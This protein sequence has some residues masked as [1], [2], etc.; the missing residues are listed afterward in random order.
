MNKQINA[1][2]QGDDYQALFFWY[3]ALK[4][5]YPHTGVKKVVYEADNV[6]SFDDVVVYYKKDK[7]GLDCNN[8]PIN[9]DFFQVKFHVTNSNAFTWNGL[10]DPKFVNA[11][12]VSIM[13]RLRNAQEMYKE[14]IGTR[15][16]LVST[17]S[18]DSQDKLSEIVSNY[19]DGI[20]IDKLFDNRPRTQMA[21]MRRSM[22]EH[23]NLTED[24]LKEMLMSFRIWHNYSSYQRIIEEINNDLMHLG[25]KP[26]ENDSI[27]NPYV[28]LIKQWSYRGKSEFNKD[29][30]IEECKREGLFL[31]NN[32]SDSDYEDVGI[33]SFYRRAENMQDE[34]EIMLCLLKFFNG[35]YIKSDYN[36]DGEIFDELNEFTKEFNS[37][38]KYR[39]HLDTHLSI[40]FV[41]G[42]LLDSKSGIEIYPMQKSM[43][44]KEF[45]YPKED[46]DK[47]YSDWQV[48]QEIVS[49]DAKD[50]ALV[51]S[52]THDISHEVN[53]FIE[54]VKLEISKIIYCNVGG[55]TRPDAILDGM[56]AHK[57]AISL[58]GLLKERRDR[59]EKKNKLHIFAA[60]PVGFM[61][62]LGKLSRSF[63][64]VVL[65]EHD[66]EGLRDE[67]Y[68]KSFELPINKDI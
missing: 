65:Y 33:R 62:Y 43:N 48:Y 58:S 32:S 7:P 22:S 50:V 17:W 14:E 41:T 25:F 21:K 57:L 68:L 44:K 51:L 11:K 35:R 8:N 18:I 5:F 15:F 23:L 39:L 52:V 34:T 24:E 63:G 45:W 6:K 30:I 28:D 61:F 26:I 59:Q 56:H 10:M 67:L 9:I 40:S 16:S 36:W 47:D 4:M 2:M 60:C 3:F 13:E 1:R 49:E 38:E 12:T 20:L 46:S 31:G 66:F 53:E 19:H 54:D 55:N 27:R 37:S 42:Y 29:F 64:K